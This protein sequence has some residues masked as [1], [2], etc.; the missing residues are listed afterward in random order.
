MKKGFTLIEL[1][2]VIAIIGILAT[3]A[4]GLY[5][6]A[7]KKAR[8]SVRISHLQELS[9]VLEIFYNDH[10]AYPPAD[11]YPVDQTNQAIPSLGA[12][13]ANANTV[14]L[15]LMKSN[16]LKAYPADPL[17]INKFAYFYASADED[18]ALGGLPYQY[19]MLATKFESQGTKDSK[20]AVAKDGGGGHDDEGGDLYEI[21]NGVGEWSIAI[22]DWDA[23]GLTGAYAKDGTVN[24]TSGM[25]IGTGSV[26]Y[27][28]T[29]TT[30]GAA[31]GCNN[32]HVYW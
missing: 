7:Q 13:G 1:L 12:S 8:D 19:Y 14:L 24:S 11:D 21:G 27:I 5:T 23:I 18:I 17:H 3:G 4:I 2:V 16:L 30:G 10:G 29:G 9:T 25:S 6:E 22:A 32:S 31:G 20:A 28:C 26:K 15:T